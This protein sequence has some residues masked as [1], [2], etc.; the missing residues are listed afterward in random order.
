MSPKFCRIHAKHSSSPRKDNSR[1]NVSHAHRQWHKR[2]KVISESRKS[3]SSEARKY[4][5]WTEFSESKGDKESEFNKPALCTIACAKDL[6]I[7]R[8]YP[9]GRE[10]E[11]QEER[12]MLLKRRKEKEAGCSTGFIN[13]Q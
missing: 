4:N 10:G 12:K 13:I 6:R 1:I 5:P 7:R 11:E 2:S 3:R 9:K 8:E